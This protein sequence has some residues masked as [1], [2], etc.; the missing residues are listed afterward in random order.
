TV[1]ARIRGIAYDGNSYETAAQIVYETDAATGDNDMP[2][3]ISFQTTPDGS[4][5]PAERMRITNAG[6]IRFN[7][8]ST[9]GIL[10]TT[11]GDGTLATGSVNLASSEV[12]GVLPV[13][14]G[15]TGVSNIPANGVVIGNGTSPI[16]TVAPGA[17]G[18]VL[19]SDGTAWT[20]GDASGSFI[21]NQNAVDQTANFRISG[22]GRANTSFQ[23]P[24]YT[25]ADAG[26]VAIRPNTNSTTA[27]Q[28]QNSGGSSIMNVDAT[29][30]RVGIGTTAPVTALHVG[31]GTN[32]FDIQL[33]VDGR[34]KSNSALGGLWMDDNNT[35]FVGNANANEI[36]F[37]V[38]PYNNWSFFIRKT[39][40]NVGIRANTDHR[41]NIFE[42]D[43]LATQHAVNVVEQNAGNA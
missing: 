42:G 38:A 43:N 1:L 14:N 37:W 11:G 6:T 8:Y 18:N 12:T 16:T 30:N 24:V 27:I 33:Q 7:A 9:N 21:R 10:K 23:S 26:T 2:G 29:N 15:G 41:L 36:G 5:T 34:I 20:S 3:R 31:P 22:I 25:R 35:G 28:L 19:V 40:G 13:S 39:D 4:A 32:N 17:S